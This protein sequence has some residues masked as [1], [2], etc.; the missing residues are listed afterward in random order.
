MA[1]RRLRM[2]PAWLESVKPEPRP[3][4]WRD[5]LQQG[6][7]LRVET[8]GRKTWIA[9]YTFHARD[10]RYK[11]GT[12]PELSLKDARAAAKDVLADAQR[13]TDPQAKRE[14][15]RIGGSVADAVSAWLADEKQGPA[16]KW[17]GGLEG[18]SARS[19]LPHIRRLEREL[20]GKR[21]PELA[22]K[23]VERFVSAPEAAATRN[24]ALTALRG[25]F[26]W[27]GRKG[28][29]QVDPSAGFEKER[30]AERSRTLTD[31]ELRALVRGFD[32]TRYSRVVR[33]LALS[34]LRRDEVLGARWEWFDSDSKVLTIPPEA[35]KT[36]RAR[37]E[38][39]RVALSPAAVA[40]LA[41]QRKAQLAEGSRC[42]WIFATKTGER[43]HPDALKP[44]LNLLRGL[45]SNGQPPST[46]KPAHGP[47]PKPRPA[48]LAKDATIHDVR[49]S[50]A[51]RLLNA[52]H[53][54]PHVIDHAIL[55]H[56]R[57]RLIRTYQPNLPL[58]EAREALTRWAEELSRILREKPAETEARPS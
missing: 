49:R 26:C 48:A 44:T 43:P 39:R 55:G 41:E 8:S 58:D 52:L 31:D 18:G 38:P 24:R 51:N 21:L 40:L 47:E 16:S 10:R 45:K 22:R 32:E 5:T 3:V 37:G 17:K 34:A 50:V 46:K 23:D 36:G 4:E 9:R 42:E 27:C 29:V 35:E 20:G 56:V 30:E 33:L 57:P 19:F 25:F 13:E 7:V 15:L 53:I 11:V 28:L 6:L 1:T 14:A 54:A 12:F 2:S